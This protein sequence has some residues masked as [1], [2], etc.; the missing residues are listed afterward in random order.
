[1]GIAVVFVLCSLGVGFTQGEVL[2]MADRPYLKVWLFDPAD[3]YCCYEG[4]PKGITWVRRVKANNTG[5]LQS[6]EVSERVTTRDNL[7]GGIL[8]GT[9]TITSVQL[10][11]SGLYHCKLNGTETYTHGTYLHVYKPLEKT[12]AIKESTKN[13]ILTAEGILLLMCVLVPSATILFKSK[14]LNELEK[15]KVKMEEENIYQGLNLDD[16]CATYD[17]IERSQGQ[18][19]Y[20][21]VGNIMEE[22]EEVQLEKP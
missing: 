18:G 7:K 12:I 15:K 17:Q 6:V 16:C 21:D 8:C 19:P 11:D 2:L 13:M 14:S 1:M 10:N 4:E 20:Q 22:G 9:L 5:Y 3:L